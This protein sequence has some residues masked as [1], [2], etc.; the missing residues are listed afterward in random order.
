MVSHSFY[1]EDVPFSVC[2]YSYYA[3]TSITLGHVRPHKSHSHLTTLT[4]LLLLASGD[5]SPNPG[6]LP[7]NIIP[8]THHLST[9]GC[10]RNAHALISIPLLPRTSPPLS[11]ALWNARSVCNKLTSVH[12]LFISNSLNLLAITETWIQDSDTAS[13]A[14]L[15]H[16]GLHW[17]HSPRSGG[18]KGGGVGILLS[19]QSRFQILS[20][21]PS[22]SL[23]SFESHCIR[24]FSPAPLRIAVIYRPPGPISRF[25]DDFSAWLPYFLSSEIPTII[26]GDFNIPPV[27]HGTDY[28][29]PIPPSSD[30][31]NNEE[32]DT[33]GNDSDAG[34]MEYM[35][36]PDSDIKKP[37]LVSQA[38]LGHPQMEVLKYIISE[39]NPVESPTEINLVNSN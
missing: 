25:L 6:P 28:P 30:A 8:H 5:I 36:D 18:Q 19:P 23:P 31:M 16:G 7:S 37:H 35:N 24:L 17:T 12:D 21:P 9:S 26:L 20:S 4:L 10:S 11:C 27:A 1:C 29:V 13:P 34:A 38:K 15:C 2:F 14:A 3:I 32:S 33:E 39:D 22:L